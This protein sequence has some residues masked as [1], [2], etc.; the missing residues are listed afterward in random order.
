MI[1]PLRRRAASVI[2]VAFVFLLTALMWHREAIWQYADTLAPLV[3]SGNMTADEMVQR[4]IEDKTRIVASL[5]TFPGRMEQVRLSLGSLFSQSLVLDAVYIHIPDKVD[6]FNLTIDESALEKDI[7]EL[8]D[9]FGSRLHIN[10]GKDFGPATKLLGTLKVERDP[11]TLIVTVD[12]DTEYHSDTMLELYRGYIANP[13]HFVAAACEEL[14]SFE[15][16]QWV[17]ISDG[18]VCNGW[19]CAYKGIMYRAGMFDDSIFD[20]TDVPKGC[21]IHDDVFLSGFLY[22]KGIRPYHVRLPFDTVVAHHWRPKFTVGST[23]NVKELQK[24]CI[25]YFNFFE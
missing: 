17:Y 23:P 13:N 21:V 15:N 16:T 9:K 4:R 10:R 2:L 22:R 5:S 24:D 11:S 19:G 7:T 25:K 6:R 18:R 12:D 20:Y 8:V 1:L 14:V 3:S